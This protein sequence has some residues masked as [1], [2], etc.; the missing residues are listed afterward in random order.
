VSPNPENCVLPITNIREKQPVEL[1]EKRHRQS[2]HLAF[3]LELDLAERTPRVADPKAVRVMAE[4]KIHA[5][6]T[7]AGRGTNSAIMT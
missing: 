5:M 7:G 6:L 2:P 3:D 4:A 1:R